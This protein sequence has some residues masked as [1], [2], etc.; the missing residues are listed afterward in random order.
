MSSMVT[1]IMQPGGGIL[2][3]PFV[4]GVISLLLVLTL[5]GFMAGVARIHMAILSFLGAGL[6]FSLSMFESE[7]KKARGDCKNDPVPS[8]SATTN[9]N[10]TD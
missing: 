8:T 5:A 1:E 9:N 3:L 10:K 6:L 2:L 7:F 4:R